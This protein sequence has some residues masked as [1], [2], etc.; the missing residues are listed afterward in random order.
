MAGTSLFSKEYLKMFLS[1]RDIVTFAF[2]RRTAGI[3]SGPGPE[4]ADSWSMASMISS[5]SK[6]ISV[7][8]DFAPLSLFSLVFSPRSSCPC[9][10]WSSSPCSAHWTPE[11]GVAEGAAGAGEAGEPV[12]IGLSPRH[13]PLSGAQASLRGTGLSPRHRPLS[14]VVLYCSSQFCVILCKPMLCYFVLVNIVLCCGSHVVLCCAK[15]WFFCTSS[16]S[17]GGTVHYR[18]IL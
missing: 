11:G 5:W 15:Q 9:P 2:L 13:R 16:R 17:R 8:F 1:I 10:S 18:S 7:S 3:P 12:V 14:N 6:Y 4:N